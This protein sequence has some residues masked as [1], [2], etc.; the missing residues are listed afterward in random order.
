MKKNVDFTIIPIFPVCWRFRLQIL[1]RLIRHISANGSPPLQLFAQVV[2]LPW[3]LSLRLAW[4]ICKTV[5]MMKGLGL[6]IWLY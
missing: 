5:C 2:T 6:N 4:Y 3:R 1:D